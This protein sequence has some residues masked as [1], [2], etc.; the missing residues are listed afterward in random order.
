M[1]C[2]KIH[3]EG[4]VQGVGFRPTA[5][6]IAC[7][8]NISGEVFNTSSGVII[9]LFGSIAQRDEY[10]DAL[11]ANLSPLALITAIVVSEVP[12]AEPSNGVFSIINS[13]ENTK[14][15]AILSPD[16]GI[17][18]SCRKE[19]LD[20]KN[21]RYQYPFISCTQCG[22]RYSIL[23]G[24]PYDR[25]RSAM[26]D[27]E[28]CS[29]CLAEYHHPND[30]RY[31]S[32]TNS[33][34]ECGMQLAFHPDQG[35]SFAHPIKFVKKAISIIKEGKI[36]AV[37]GSAGFLL[38]A[39]A[40]NVEAVSLLRE[41]KKRPRKPLALMVPDSEVFDEYFFT[42]HPVLE[43]MESPARPI[44]LCK[45]RKNTTLSITKELIAPGLDQLGVCFPADPLMYLISKHFSKPIIATS[46]NLHQ[47]PLQ[48]ENQGAIKNLFGIADAVLYHNRAIHF[49]QDDSV[50]RVAKRSCQ[51]IILRRSRGM[52]PTFWNIPKTKT[53]TTILALGADLKSTFALW[54]EYNVYVSQYL[55]NLESIDSQECF[56]QVLNKLLQLTE[57][58]PEL[59]LL[60]RH[61]EY[62]SRKF[63]DVFPSVDFVEVPHHEA[64]FAALLWEH[65][66]LDLSEPVLGIIWDGSGFGNDGAIWGAEFFVYFEGQF[67]RRFSFDYFDF[68]LGDKMSKEP[69]IAA[70]SLCH[71]L[72]E[73]PSFLQEKFT[74]KEW[75]LYT[76]MLSNGNHAQTS[77][78]GRVFDAIAS[79]LGLTDFNSF[80]G[81]AA[82]LLENIAQTYFDE[83]PAM[84]ISPYSFTETS[85]NKI[86]YAQILLQIL[87]DKAVGFDPGLIAA[88]FHV[89]LVR[90]I[91][92]FLEK[93]HCQ[94][95]GF[96]GGVFQNA[97]LVDLLQQELGGKYRLLF[98]EQMSPNDENIS[99]G[100]M[101]W[102]HI[103]NKSH[104]IK[105]K[106]YVFSDSR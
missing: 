36:L 6:R 53:D 70:L 80:E 81:E 39:D 26:K 97:L 104:K 63:L 56:M 1:Q 69:R 51:K 98:H 102:Y 14:K 85:D 105:T 57:K 59:L 21:P 65:A 100:Q 58:Q 106:T 92:Y 8:K 91:A 61:P 79:I 48:F 66:A 68:F 86:E 62:H 10:L 50:C 96:S 74:P 33:C 35:L 77:S 49:P 3:I 4:Q 71:R 84:E 99:L 87:Q 95:L 75:S 60:D 18:E 76:K 38:I 45:P 24:I 9:R 37:K 64:H 52:A 46:G 67:E 72:G 90:I 47:S 27:F 32:Q 83:Q 41:R 2:W 12:N 93:I 55:G 82:M 25:H 89:T 88:R 28:M 19:V 94:T 22:P 23:E 11:K 13:K 16:F 43:A 17:C 15:N 78:M 54:D 5:A 44:V 103:K 101:A 31:H 30:R 20:R 42:D 40:S 29:S 34:P 73:Y 7:E